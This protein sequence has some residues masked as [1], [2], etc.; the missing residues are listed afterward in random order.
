[1]VAPEDTTKFHPVFVKELTEGRTAS[2]SKKPVEQRRKEILNFSI[3]TLMDMV[4][5]DAKFWLSNA[6]LAVE[7]SAIVKVGKN[8]FPQIQ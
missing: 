7:M 2:T 5:D 3:S 1:M 6:S 8:I 4:A